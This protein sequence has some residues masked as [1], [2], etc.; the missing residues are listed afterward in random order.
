MRQTRQMDA[1]D[2]VRLDGQGFEA[3]CR[4]LFEDILGLPLEIFAAGKDHGIDLRHVADDGTMSVVQCKHW[5]RS[6]RPALLKHMRTVERPKLDVM[7]PTRYLLAST[8]ELTVDAKNSLCRDL[9][10]HVR[11]PSD[12]YGIEQ[13]EAELKKRPTIVVRHHRLWLSGTAVLQ[14]V[15]HKNT[16]VRSSDLLDGFVE[17]A[18]TFVPTPA[19]DLAKSVLETVSV[20]LLSGIPGIGKTTMAKMLAKSYVDEGYQLVEV[21]EDVKELD[22][23]WLDDT[24]QV[25]YYD[26][27]LGQTALEHMFNKNEDSRLIKVIG[28]I[29]NTSGKKLILTTREY[30]LAQA[31]QRYPKLDDEQLDP[32]TCVIE[33]QNLTRETRAKILYR[34]VESLDLCDDDRRKIAEP[35]TWTQLIHHPNFNPRQIT[36]TLRLAARSGRVAEELLR[37]LDNPERIWAHIVEEDLDDAAVHLL[38]VLATFRFGALSEHLYEVWLDY[39]SRLSVDLDPRLFYRALRTLQGTLITIGFGNDLFHNDRIID[40]HN[41]S[42]GDY[43]QARMNG[44]LV[45]LPELLAS[46]NTA[47]Q[48]MHMVSLAS[49]FDENGEAGHLYRHSAAIAQAV[50]RTFEEVETGE[51]EEDDSWA[52]N[53]TRALSVAENLQSPDLANFVVGRIE[54]NPTEMRES[55]F[56]HLADLV[57]QIH[58]STLIPKEISRR[59][60]VKL[61]GTISGDPVAQSDTEEWTTL[62]EAHAALQFLPG[63]EASKRLAALRAAMFERAEKELNTYWSTDDGGCGDDDWSWMQTKSMLDFLETVSLTGEAKIAYERAKTASKEYDDSDYVPA[64]LQPLIRTEL[65]IFEPVRDYPVDKVEQIRK[66]LVDTVGSDDQ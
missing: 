39:R 28:R 3:L 35:R 44:N 48:A 62:V 11:S 16:V 51:S 63:A 33:L 46:V 59:L 32:L 66:R 22:N 58:E 42:V 47:G 30:I 7:R 17:C 24:K 14:G 8:V 50:I 61:L 49:Q 4:D 1:S 26:D 25:F 10:P 6:G 56:A 2:I 13:I 19:Y 12:L 57:E 53:L 43:L 15:L 9:A 23:A 60:I 31:K 45:R 20:C 54:Q 64:P 34:H 18:R 65:P 21:S 52:A 29:R 27:F 36:S 41:P 38:E 55:Y 5:V 40:F 37:N